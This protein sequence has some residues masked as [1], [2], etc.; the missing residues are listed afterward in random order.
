MDSCAYSW[1]DGEGQRHDEV[2]SA[3]LLV[4]DLTG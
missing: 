4:K 1:F 3:Q 2:E